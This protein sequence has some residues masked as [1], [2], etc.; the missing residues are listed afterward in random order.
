MI[1]VSKSDL[2]AKFEREAFAVTRYR[3]VA[4]CPCYGSSDESDRSGRNDRG[5]AANPHRALPPVPRV[6]SDNAPF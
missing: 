5:R 4:I 1:L 2:S 6:P 3:A